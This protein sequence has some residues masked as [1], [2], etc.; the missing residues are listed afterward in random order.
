MLC[1]CSV[2]IGLVMLTYSIM[3]EPIIKSF[4]ISKSTNDDPKGNLN[5]CVHI[6]CH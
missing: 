6:L 5:K 4:C 1:A 3:E 2:H